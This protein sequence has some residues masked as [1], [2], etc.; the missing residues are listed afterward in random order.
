V[1]AEPELFEDVLATRRV[2]EGKV[3]NL[4]V[5]DVE[6]PDGAH[7]KREVVEHADSVAIVPVLDD[8]RIVL[9]RQFRL[10][11]GGV[12]LEIPAGVVDPGESPAQ[13]AQR[14]LAEE[15]GYEA[16]HLELLFSMY[17]APGYCS[18]LIHLFVATG[19]TPAHRAPEAD[20]FIEPLVVTPQQA[21]SLID[22]GAIRDAKTIAG[23]LA[24]LN[25]TR[26]PSVA[27]GHREN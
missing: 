10:P 27:Q 17:L 22:D 20:E 25:Q 12:L 7:S 1:T 11:A 18:E 24:Y 3:V 6:L 9:I 2:Y 23:I 26:G 4:R 5:D 8:G 13:C 16:A 14:E 21:R 15:I 19:L